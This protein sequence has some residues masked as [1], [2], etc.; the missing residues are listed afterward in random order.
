MRYGTIAFVGA[1]GIGVHDRARPPVP[2]VLS[3]G[4]L[5]AFALLLMIAATT[6]TWIVAGLDTDKLVLLAGGA[7]A[8]G[9][10][11]LASWR[12]WWLLLLLF[13]VRASLDALKPSE[14]GGSG[15]EAGTI[16]GA[17]FLISATAWLW[18]QWRSGNLMPVSRAGIAL[19]ALAGALVLSS[20]GAEQIAN[21]LQ[22]S[23]KFVAI[24]VMFIVLEQTFL[25]HPER[26]AG[27]LAAVLVS[28]VVPAIVGISEAISSG[29]P[30]S[31]VDVSRIRSTFVHANVF[32]SYLVVIGL[33]AITLIPYLPRWRVALVAIVVVTVPMLLLTYARGAW[34]AFY[35]GVVLIG[36]AQ[37]RILLVL[38][39]AVTIVAVLAVPSVSTRLSDLNLAEDTRG[40][41]QANSAEWR[42]D[43]W[44][45]VLPL[46]GENPVTGIGTDMIRR[47]ADYRLPAHSVFVDVIV[48]AGALGV[49]T[50]IA[51]VVTMWAALRRAARLLR[52][53]LGRGITVASAAIGLSLLVQFFSESLLIQ[54]AV[55]W[56]AMVPMAW[57]AA[58]SRRLDGRA[59][60][61]A[62]AA[63]ATR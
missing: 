41:Q 57:A 30:E 4:S 45:N 24:A 27:A 16:V 59:G 37:S 55:L 23:L 43:Y 8:A 22:S 9:L 28:L 38:I 12:F 3:F 60:V 15:L 7:V 53:R 63:I 62:T 17:V 2:R 29:L 18:V 6:I 61:R 11:L 51:A 36:L 50:L 19:L 46:V 14:I 31:G 35:L 52:D 54:P 44:A 47:T 34:I 25:V 21:S 40:N 56:Y 33:L 13:A 10:V 1:H 58:A 49:A 26:I 48:E 5:V 42:V 20:L 32:A 39:A